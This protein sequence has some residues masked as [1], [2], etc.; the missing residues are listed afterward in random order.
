M[1][2]DGVIGRRGITATASFRRP[3]H[4]PCRKAYWGDGGPLGEL[5][6]LVHTALRHWLVPDPARQPIEAFPHRAAGAPSNPF[7]RVLP[8]IRVCSVLLPS[9][10]RAPRCRWFLFGPSAYDQLMVEPVAPPGQSAPIS[11]ADRLAFAFGLY[12]RAVLLPVVAYP[13]VASQQTTVGQACGPV[14][15][16]LVVEAH[17]Q[18]LWY[19]VPSK[20]SLSYHIVDRF[21][22]DGCFHIDIMSFLRIESEP[23]RLHIFCIV[24][25]HH[26]P[27]F[28]L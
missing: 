8:V 11:E 7:G 12:A 5:S 14:G 22:L 20:K 3:C 17:T 9:S 15:A 13:P 28:M 19:F 1:A 2:L 18:Q 4:K 6:F 23:H 21:C 26:T 10:R 27:V 24:N 25:T 16:T